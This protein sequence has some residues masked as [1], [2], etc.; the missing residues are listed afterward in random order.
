MMPEPVLEMELAQA[1]EVLTEDAGAVLVDVRSEA[2]WQ[3]VGVPDLRSVG[4]VPVLVPWARY[5]GTPNER[6]VDEVRAAGVG[7]DQT[8]LLLC[9]SGQRSRAAGRA[10]AL[11]GY[12]RCINV[13]AGFEGPLDEQGH[14]TGGWRGAG[15]PW[16]QS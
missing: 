8:V 4:K 13:T 14:R 7:P 2:E 12:A 11:V 6:F 15:L 1:W 16:R 5:P 10:L 9:R 3:F